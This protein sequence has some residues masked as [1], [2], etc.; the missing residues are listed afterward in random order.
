[1]ITY[2]CKP[3]LNDSEVLE[4]CRNGFLMLKGVVP[5]KI[6]KNLLGT[7]GNQLAY[8]MKTGL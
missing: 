5:D 2:D 8:S 6:N 3:T 4:V 1:M 7:Q